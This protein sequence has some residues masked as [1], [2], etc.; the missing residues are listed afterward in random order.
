MTFI[1]PLSDESSAWD[2]LE[3]QRTARDLASRSVNP[4]AAQAIVDLHNAAPHL[5]AGAKYSLGQAGITPTNPIVQQISTQTVK[6]KAKKGFGF[7][8]FGDVLKSGFSN[9]VGKGLSILGEEVLDPLGGAVGNVARPV[10]RGTMMGLMAP[11]EEGVGLLRN[12]ATSLPDKFGE[13]AAGVAAGGLTGGALGAAGGGGVFS[14]LT[15]PIG[16]V[17][18]AVIGGA[19]GALGPDV[20]GK[21]QWTPSSSLGIATGKLLAG[22]KVEAGSGYFIGHNSP[23]FQQQAEEARSR[24]SLPGANG[25]RT[26][27]TPG[28]SVATVVAEPG[29]FQYKALSGL[30]DGYAAM[31]LD[32]SALALGKSSQI[33]AARRTVDPIK[34]AELLAGNFGN[35][36]AAHISTT[37]SPSQIAKLFN[38][39]LNAQPALLAELADLTDIPAIKTALAPILGADVTTL[40]KLGVQRRVIPRLAISETRAL[41]DVPT[42]AWEYNDP[43]TAL[44]KFN[45]F[46]KIGKVPD[47]EIE[48]MSDDFIRSLAGPNTGRLPVLEHAARAVSRVAEAHGADPA[49]ARRLTTLFTSSIE[50]ARQ[51]TAQVVAD[52]TALSD[53]PWLRVAGDQQS[54]KSP[55]DIAEFLNHA[56]PIPDMQE[57]QRAISTFNRITTHPLTNAATDT[58]DSL[59]GAWKRTAIIRAAYVPRV[60]GEEQLRMATAGYDS[61]FKH[62]LSFIAGRVA[63]KSEATAV[64]SLND[65]PLLMEEEMLGALNRGRG[66]S[67]LSRSGAAMKNR[68]RLSVNDGDIYT[69]GWREH[70]LSRIHASP[71]MNRISRLLSTGSAD[72]SNTI[73]TIDDLKSAF[74]EGNL[75]NLKDDLARSL[76]GTPDAGWFDTPLNA[77]T[78]IDS[79]VERV[80]HITRSDSTLLEAGYRGTA[81]VDTAPAMQALISSGNHPPLVVGDI[82]GASLAP[83]T[84]A[85][86]DKVTDFGFEWIATKPTNFFS[87]S[88]VA[89]QAYWKN[90]ERMLP[91]MSDA[92]KTRALNLARESN[93]PSYRI[94]ALES[95]SAT[96]FTGQALSLDDV[97]T[98]AARQATNEVKK[99]LYDLSER[100]QWTQASRL[101]FP[102]A[103]AWQEMLT[104]WSKLL[105]E[106]PVAIRRTGQ[107]VEG[108]RGAGF[109]HTNEYGE[110][111]FNYPGSEFV[112]K[113]LVGAPIPITGSVSGLNLFANSPVLPGFGPVAQIAASALIPDKPE[114][115]WVQDVVSPFG[116]GDTSTGFI[117][118]FFPAWSQKVR[119]ALTSDDSDRVFNNTVYDM[120]RYLQSAGRGDISTIEGQEQLTRDSISMAKRMYLL[121]SL[122][123]FTLPSAP[124]PRAVAEDKDGRVVTQFKLIDEYHKLQ[125]EPSEGGVGWE[126]APE[127]FLRRYG[128]DAL[129]FMQPKTKGGG[130][131]LEDTLDWIRDN[132]SL[133]KSYKSTYSFFAPHSGEFSMTAYERQIAT[134][135]RDTLTPDEAYK[136]ANSRVASM[137]F[138]QAKAQAGP[139]PSTEARAWLA[140]VKDALITE[141]PGYEPESFDPARVPRQIRELERAVSEPKLAST[142]TG[143][144]LTKYMAARARAIELSQSAGLPSFTRAKKAAPVRAWLRDVGAALIAE[145]PEFAEVWDLVLSNEMA[146]D[147]EESPTPT[148]TPTPTDDEEETS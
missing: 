6:A 94:A 59:L 41:T 28:R 30:I 58:L 50:D 7:H 91:A 130:A 8:S 54:L 92:D 13:I 46:L 136:L 12:V 31:K 118:S 97:H 40:P 93:L 139:K 38:G 135:E 57:I 106:N 109:F 117:E 17:G 115:D 148:S 23:L 129:L 137:K 21:A 80:T 114:F 39:E 119:K 16:M 47:V 82:H 15:A 116:R 126:N 33:R 78:Y 1:P 143:Q 98:V 144:A 64:K 79:L 56:V 4:R 43:A 68:A 36:L 18:G 11:I 90:V 14:W 2:Q 20:E 51:F 138:R 52:G 145:H 25:T 142:P 72:A 29:S 34:A 123:S 76:D 107:V 32:P 70:E 87:R 48:S 86:F 110:E 66:S 44:K 83:K 24:A 124:Q 10:I 104:T 134:G 61:L 128:E 84:K 133:A 120:A 146:D 75:Q 60:V 85:L 55:H 96:P 49:T 89:E 99:L 140:Q 45:D 5:P 22:E 67:V 71:L 62:P 111:V 125:Q 9:T 95:R 81:Q 100:K 65:I 63:A 113:L 26:A 141:Y 37:T 3:A 42:G 35:D 101:V 147:I 131:P 121:R 102:F 103:E 122:G 112:S 105:V 53:I 88:P 127:E 74:R 77:D 69:V 27:W 132:P 108:A 19:A 73:N